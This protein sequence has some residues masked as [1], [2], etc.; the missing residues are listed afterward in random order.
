MFAG[1]VLKISFENFPLHSHLANSFQ[2]VSAFNMPSSLSLIISHFWFLT[3][4]ERCVILPFTW[5]FRGHCK[6]INCLNFTIVVSK[7]MGEWGGEEEEQLVGG[8]EGTP[9]HQLSSSLTW[10]WFVVPPIIT[11]VHQKSLIKD[12][13]NK[14]N[15]EKN[16]KY[17]EIY[18]NVT[19]RHKLS[20]WCW[21]MVPIILLNSGL[22][23]IFNLWKTTNICEAQ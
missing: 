4:S 22:P 12:H 16:L 9:I 17:S 13:H 11:I 18:Q 8:A 10:E 21:K 2:P 20:K 1:I 15:N 5:T 6:V 23:Q 7:G 14:Y 3:S 19:R